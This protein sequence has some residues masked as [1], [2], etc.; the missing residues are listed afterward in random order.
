MAAKYSVADIDSMRRAVRCI[1]FEWGTRGT[2]EEVE[3]ML[4][5]YMLNG[6]TAAEL[7]TKMV[8]FCVRRRAAREELAELRARTAAAMDAAKAAAEDIRRR[9]WCAEWFGGSRTTR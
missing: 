9:G 1:Y 2:T 4:R 7:D 5:T 6:T 8:D 3:A